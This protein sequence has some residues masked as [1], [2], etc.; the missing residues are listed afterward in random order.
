MRNNPARPISN[1]FVLTGDIG[2]RGRG[3]EHEGRGERSQW[4]AV[5][6]EGQNREE[7]QNGDNWGRP[8]GGT[9]TE[10]GTTTAEEGRRIQDHHEKQVSS[11]RDRG[12]CRGDRLGEMEANSEEWSVR[13]DKDSD[14]ET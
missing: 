8:R 14:I 7:G 9:E 11:V 12:E 2:G 6:G 13:R 1:I 10:Q 5:G 4:P 3:Q